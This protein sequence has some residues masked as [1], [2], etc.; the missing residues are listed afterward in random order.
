M[1]RKALLPYVFTKDMGS[2]PQAFANDAGVS[3]EDLE[4]FWTALHKM[5]DMEP[6]RPAGN[7]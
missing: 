4:L 3:K 6:I 1:G 7:G 5:W 2:L